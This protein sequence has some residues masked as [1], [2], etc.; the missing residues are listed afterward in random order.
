MDRVSGAN[1][2]T[3]G[4]KRF[5]QD[6]NLVGGITGTEFVAADF[7]ARQEEI[8]GVIEGAGLTASASSTTQMLAAIKRLAGGNTS[9]V[10]T[11][12]T[13]LTPD[14]AGLVIVNATAASVVL[15][16]PAGTAAAGTPMH[17]EVVRIDGVAAHTVTIVLQSGDGLVVPGPLAV[18]PEQV[19]R[20]VALGGTAW[21]TAVENAPA[22]LGTTGYEFTASGTLRQ[23]GTVNTA[24]G[25]G[26][27][28]TF[29]IPFPTAVDNII[30]VEHSAS[31]WGST[32]QPTVFGWN[33]KSN[34]DFYLYGL[35]FVTG[36]GPTYQ[37]GLTCNYV[38]TGR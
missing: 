34:A 22:S 27:V 3:V 32:P 36:S 19:V 35:R 18:L 23:W 7:N 29:P 38:A 31:G 6:Q 21:V 12:N 25:N 10:L 5:Y 16:M 37:S 8:L 13:T 14:N 17:F 30:V 4:G 33:A 15:T 11:L 20:V 24:T 26:D 28:I 9:A 2:V 1:Y